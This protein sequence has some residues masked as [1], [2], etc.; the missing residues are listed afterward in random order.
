[1]TFQHLFHLDAATA[2]KITSGGSRTDATQA[3]FPVLH[4]MAIS[5]LRL[6]VNGM[7]EPHWHPNANELGYCIEGKALMTIFS[8]GA[9]HSTFLI[10]PGALSFVPKGSMHHIENIGDTPLKMLVCFDH[11]LPEDLELSSSIGVMPLHILADTFKQTPEF[12]SGLDAKIKPVFITEKKNRT[13]L[14]LDWQTNSFK[15]NIETTQPQIAT[16]GGTVKMSNSFLMPSL[17]GLS[18]YSVNLTKNGA[19]EPH[20]HPNAH[21]LNYL[22]S[23][24]ARITLLSPGGSED[25]FDMKAGDMSFM[26]QGYLHHIENSGNDPA[27]FAI[28]FSHTA[29]SDIG[30]S[31]CLGAYSN[32]VLASLFNVTLSYFDK[33]PKYQS[34]LF[35][36]SGGG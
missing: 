18:L 20:W 25:T 13:E 17:K 15:F 11:A 16:S 3:N 2:Q 21:E 24:T 7:R 26:P 27:H 22:I 9:N 5:L 28:F 33:I 14:Q 32:D 36:I 4:D 30:L 29:P 31:G 23:G 10:E 8:P 35:V 12:F 19:R 6:T 34:D 1:M